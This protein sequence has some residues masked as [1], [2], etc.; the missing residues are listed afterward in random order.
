MEMVLNISDQR[1]RS[2]VKMRRLSGGI[3]FAI[4][5]GFTLPLAVPIAGDAQDPV[6]RTSIHQLKDKMGKDGIL[7]L[8]VRSGD[9][10]ARSK[11]KIKG[12][13]RISVVHLAQKAKE[14]PKEQEI[15]TY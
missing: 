2:T 14:L 1:R 13:V 7:I 12:A 15:I 10:Y 3:V 11:H 9:D 4:I 8:D 6:S 5:M